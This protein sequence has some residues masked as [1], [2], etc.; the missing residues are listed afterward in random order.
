MSTETTYGGWVTERSS[1][2]GSPSNFVRIVG[3]MA[4]SG[5]FLASVGTGGQMSVGHLQRAVMEVLHAEP[6]STVTE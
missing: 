5:A 4:V 2:T 6:V 1:A 3:W